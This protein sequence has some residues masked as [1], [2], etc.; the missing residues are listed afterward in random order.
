LS[1]YFQVPTLKYLV[2][3]A[4]RKYLTFEAAQ[5]YLVHIRERNFP[6]LIEMMANF[7]AVNVTKLTDFTF[8]KVGKLMLKKILKRIV[9]IVGTGYGVYIHC[10]PPSSTTTEEPEEEDEEI[11]EF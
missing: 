10:Y 6:D 11:E 4:F 3:S 7:I 9:S 8:D 5:T 2:N 1:D